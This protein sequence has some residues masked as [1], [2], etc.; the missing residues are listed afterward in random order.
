MFSKVSAVSF[1]LFFSGF[2]QSAIA[3]SL[4]PAA[5]AFH[6]KLEEILKSDSGV[7]IGTVVDSPGQTIKITVGSPPREVTHIVPTPGAMV[8]IKIEIPIRGGE[9]GKIIQVRNGGGGNCINVFGVGQRWFFNGTQYLSGST[10]LADEFGN[11][12]GTGTGEVFH[13]EIFEKFPE[14][15]KLPP[16]SIVVQDYLKER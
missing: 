1:G 10:L 13:E 8:K 9:V 5:L 6:P 16:P 14:V 15:I 3:C 2:A 4:S 11:R 12:W 7:F